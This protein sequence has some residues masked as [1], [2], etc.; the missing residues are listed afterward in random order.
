MLKWTDPVEKISGIA[1]KKSIFEKFTQSNPSH[2]TNGGT[3]LG[4]AIAKQIIEDHSGKIWIE[5]NVNKGSVFK[6]F[7][8]K[9]AVQ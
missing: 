3:G 6:F 4:L 5:D 2:S 8:P 9:K 1:D 7:I